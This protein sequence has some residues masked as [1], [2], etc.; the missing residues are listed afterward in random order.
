MKNKKLSKFVKQK[1]INVAEIF[2]DLK[3]IQVL[4]TIYIFRSCNP[5]LKWLLVLY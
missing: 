5:S 2:G 1:V 4:S 3:L